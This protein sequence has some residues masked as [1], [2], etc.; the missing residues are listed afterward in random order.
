VG[1]QQRRYRAAHSR[2]T[3]KALQ[4]YSYGTLTKL[5]S[6][7]IETNSQAGSALTVPRPVIAAA[8]NPHSARLWV[9]AGIPVACEAWLWLAAV[10]Q[11]RFT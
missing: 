4:S 3:L 10:R 6:D 5:E 7:A 2:K 8:R 9:F 1:L 11:A